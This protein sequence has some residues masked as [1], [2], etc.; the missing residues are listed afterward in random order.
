MYNYLYI[1]KLSLT[2]NENGQEPGLPWPGKH[3]HYLSVVQGKDLRSTL[4]AA[5]TTRIKIRDP[6]SFKTKTQ[7][8]GHSTTAGMEHDTNHLLSYIPIV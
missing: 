8:W 4:A 6:N 7:E 2:L 1:N 3:L 5:K